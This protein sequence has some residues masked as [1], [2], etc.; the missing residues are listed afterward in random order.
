M[1]DLFMKGTSGVFR[2]DGKYRTVLTRTWGMHGARILW[3]AL[4][5]STA[6]GRRERSDN[7]TGRSS[8]ADSW[9]FLT[10]W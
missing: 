9:G 7:H 10:V 4:N 5:P 1:S 6:D 3:G 2:V 8:S